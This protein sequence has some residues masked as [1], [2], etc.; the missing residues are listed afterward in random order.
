MGGGGR[1]GGY[2]R[3]AQSR[4]LSKPCRKHNIEQVANGVAFT[5]R[6]LCIQNEQQI[7]NCPQTTRLGGRREGRKE[8]REVGS[9]E[10]KEGK[11]GAN[12]INE[13]T[14]RLAVAPLKLFKVRFAGTT[15]TTST[16]MFALPSGSFHCSPG[17]ET[18]FVAGQNGPVVVLVRHGGGDGGPINP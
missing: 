1:L 17:N 2:S 6:E 13:P 10:E 4:S 7:D 8:R 18:S 3:A 11:G 16:C 14:F 12:D 5:C 15:T 9:E